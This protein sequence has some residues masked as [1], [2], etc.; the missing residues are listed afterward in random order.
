MKTN[1]EMAYD[2]RGHKFKWEIPICK[3]KSTYEI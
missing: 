1:R 2:P 3:V